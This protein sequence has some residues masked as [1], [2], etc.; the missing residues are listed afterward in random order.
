MFLVDFFTVNICTAEEFNPMP[1]KDGEFGEVGGGQSGQ[2]VDGTTTAANNKGKYEAVIVDKKVQMQNSLGMLTHTNI[3]STLT[4]DEK[5]HD[6]LLHNIEMINQTEIEKNEKNEKN[7]QNHSSFLQTLLKQPL[8]QQR[9]IIDQIY[10]NDL[11]KF[12]SFLYTAT[13]K[14]L[15]FVKKTGEFIGILSPKTSEVFFN[16]IY[17]LPLQDQTPHITS[18]KSNQVKSNNMLLS[19]CNPIIRPNYAELIKTNKDFK[20]MD[21]S[22]SSSTSD[23]IKQ[24]LTMT[25]DH[26]KVDNMCQAIGGKCVPIVDGY[27]VEVIFCGLFGFIYFMIAWPKLKGLDQ[28]PLSA[29][30]PGK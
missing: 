26:H 2:V 22:P 11:S 20:N 25:H 29:W 17:L 6:Y 10:T 21:F 15:N 4:I 18:A 5:Y 23:F 9:D 16:Q 12:D 1:K 7:N 30:R 13:H 8:P 24:A 14:F 28:L 27:F 19:M 3:T